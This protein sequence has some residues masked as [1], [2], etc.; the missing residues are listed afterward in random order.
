[1][2]DYASVTNP[3]PDEAERTFERIIGNSTALESV[4]EQVQ[5]IAPTDRLSSSRRKPV[6]GK[7]LITH[8]IHNASQR[9]G[10]FYKT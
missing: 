9:S 5:Q 4:L 7:E 6:T 10:C 2:G 3:G 1:V 8:A